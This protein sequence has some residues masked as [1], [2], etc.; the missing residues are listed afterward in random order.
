VAPRPQ[1]SPLE[2]HKPIFKKGFWSP[3]SVC[4]SYARQ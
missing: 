4:A 2:L 1:C 3:F